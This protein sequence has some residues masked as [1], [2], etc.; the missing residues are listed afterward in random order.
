MP[1]FD[2]AIQQCAG[3]FSQSNQGKKRIKGIQTV[4]IGIK[5]FLFA[6][7]MVL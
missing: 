7:N 5:L 6:D 1:A 2:I 4:K 3:I